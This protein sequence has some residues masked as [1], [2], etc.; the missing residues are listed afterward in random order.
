MRRVEHAVSP[1]VPRVASRRDAPAAAILAGGSFRTAQHDESLYRRL[2]PAHRRG[3]EQRAAATTRTYFPG[4]RRKSDPPIAID[5]WHASTCD[6]HRGAFACPHG[7]PRRRVCRPGY[8]RDARASTRARFQDAGEMC[9]RLELAPRLRAPEAHADGVEG[10]KP[11][12]S[13]CIAQCGR[14]CEPVMYHLRS[15]LGRACGRPTHA[16]VARLPG[17]CRT[18][19][20]SDRGPTSRRS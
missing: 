20:S 13:I 15:E 11:A 5:V 6:D 12:I 16:T 18:N 17:W 3:L 7:G 4:L 14:Q 10:S 1:G 8:Q 9:A 19:S 2:R